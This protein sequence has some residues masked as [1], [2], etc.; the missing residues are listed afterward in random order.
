MFNHKIFFSLNF[1]YGILARLQPALPQR[2]GAP[3]QRADSGRNIYATEG[4]RNTKF[5]DSRSLS[6]AAD[7]PK[8]W[9]DQAV[10]ENPT[11][12]FGALTSFLS[13]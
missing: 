11:E 7:K 3:V 13:N 2:L 6:N 5:L 12:S 10:A 8:H 9:F 4:Q 1:R